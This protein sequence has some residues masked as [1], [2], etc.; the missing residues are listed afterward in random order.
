VSLLPREGKKERDIA[1]PSDIFLYEGF[2]GENNGRD[3]S[4]VTWNQGFAQ[5]RN[6]VRPIWEND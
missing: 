1:T 2:S 5:C 3:E 4:F 6:T